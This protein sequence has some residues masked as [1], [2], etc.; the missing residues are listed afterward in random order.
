[1]GTNLGFYLNF[2][3]TPRFV[4]SLASSFDLIMIW[5]LVLTAIGFSVVGKVKQGTSTAIVFGWYIFVSLVSAG[6]ASAFA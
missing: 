5:V 2:A 4:Y 3:D 6:M 1:V